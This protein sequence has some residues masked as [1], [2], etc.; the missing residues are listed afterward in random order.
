MELLPENVAHAYL[1]GLGHGAVIVDPHSVLIDYIDS[2][3]QKFD[4]FVYDF[5]VLF[6]CHGNSLSETS[7]STLSLYHSAKYFA[8]CFLVFLYGRIVLL[9]LKEF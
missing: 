7:D 1:L 6:F 2:L 9:K 3:V 4:Q 8:P 5:S